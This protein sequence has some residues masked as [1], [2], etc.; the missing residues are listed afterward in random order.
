[1]M[2]EIY[3]FVDAIVRAAIASSPHT[4]PQK[5]FQATEQLWHERVE[6]E[7]FGT[8]IPFRLKEC[9]NIP[10]KDYLVEDDE[11]A[12]DLGG[13]DEFEVV[14]FGTPPFAEVKVDGG[15]PSLY[16]SHSC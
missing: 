8:P 3:R 2:L 9:L 7:I 10:A 16:P 14:R 13:S 15:H 1:M 12:G 11:D 6:A 4:T 5:H